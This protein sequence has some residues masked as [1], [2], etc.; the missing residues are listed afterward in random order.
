MFDKAL[1]M[2]G[3]WIHQ[4]SEYA[5]VLNVPQFWICSWFRICHESKYTRVVNISGSYRVSKMP[6]Y[7]TIISEYAWICLI[8][9]QYT[10]IC[11]N[12][13]EFTWK[14]A[15]TAFALHFPIVNQCLKEPR[16]VFNSGWKYLT[17]FFR[18]Y[19]KYF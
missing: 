10:S 18:F 16:I 8:M 5:R 3:F 7:A 17:C 6:E 11:G 1:N 15:K 12:M 19:I 4:D 13:R 14:S 9:P 2:P